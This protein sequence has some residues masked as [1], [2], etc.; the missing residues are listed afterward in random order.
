MW[1]LASDTSLWD[2]IA[3]PKS[4]GASCNRI[5]NIVSLFL[6]KQEEQGPTYQLFIYIYIN[7]IIINIISINIIIIIINI[8]IIIVNI[9][10]I[11]SCCRFVLPI[12]D[13]HKLIN[14]QKDEG[15]QWFTTLV[16]QLGPD[17]FPL[18]HHVW[19]LRGTIVGCATDQVLQWRL[20]AMLS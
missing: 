12:W 8:I 7:I 1:R 9:I 5:I 4:L 17:F 13:S 14:Q 6:K 2:K 3:P 10:Y 16:R 15:H 19:H 11:Y 20:A 18:Q